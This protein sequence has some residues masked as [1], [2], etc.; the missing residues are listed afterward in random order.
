MKARLLSLPFLFLALAATCIAGD[1]LTVLHSFN[2]SGTGNPAFR[3][4]Q[5][6]A[7][8]LYGIT[9]WGGNFNG[10]SGQGCGVIYRLSPSGSGYTYTVLY[11][12]P[13]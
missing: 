12:F 10:C 1:K 9:F 5:D 11:K 3:L 13:G 8:N 6:A 4:A 7:G 2:A